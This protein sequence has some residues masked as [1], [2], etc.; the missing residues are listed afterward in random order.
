M[1]WTWHEMLWKVNGELKKCTLLSA[2]VFSRKVLTGTLFVRLLLETGRDRYFTWSYEPRE[3]V[4]V[5]SR[6]LLSALPTELILPLS[7]LRII[8]SVK[9][10]VFN[11][12]GISRFP[13]LLG[14]ARL[15]SRSCS[16]Y[17]HLVY[18]SSFM[19]CCQ[20]MRISENCVIDLCNIWRSLR[21][22]QKKRV[23]TQVNL[24]TTELNRTE[25]RRK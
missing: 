9:Q 6:D 25:D 17:S 11:N 5:W 7:N 13:R 20:S 15:L 2:N 24:L 23:F 22:K 12:K 14:Y 19:K 8:L 21:N 1:R 18:R 4:A 16:G 3:G 10:A